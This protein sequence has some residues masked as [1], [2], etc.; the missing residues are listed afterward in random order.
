MGYE[1]MY[2]HELVFTV[3]QGRVIRIEKINSG[4]TFRSQEAE[5]MQKRAKLME[6]RAVVRTAAPTSDGWVT[7]PHC[8]VRF[9][10]RDTRRWDGVS[11]LTC[12]GRINLKP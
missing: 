8:R 2:E 10:V 7:C 1:S 9:T 4:E 3:Q 6:E 12:G 11:H 5:L